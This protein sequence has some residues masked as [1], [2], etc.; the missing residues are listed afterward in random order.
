VIVCFAMLGVLYRVSSGT[1]SKSLA[2]GAL[3][4]T[5]SLLTMHTQVF[6]ITLSLSVDWP[7]IF[8]MLAKLLELL[9]FNLEMLSPECH[10]GHDSLAIRYLPGLFIPLGVVSVMAVMWAGSLVLSQIMSKHV[11]PMKVDPAINAL[12]AVIMAFYVGICKSVFDVFECRENASAPKTM[13]GHDGFLC[14]WDNGPEAQ[15]MLPA[16]AVAILIY[17]IAFGAVYIYIVVIAPSRSRDASFQTRFAFLLQRW[18]PAC[19]LWGVVFIMRNVLCSLVPSITPDALLQL[20]LLLALIFPSFVM[21]VRIWPWREHIANKQ[22]MVL[23]M[24][25]ILTLVAGLALMAPLPDLVREVLNQF[26]FLCYI[27]GVGSVGLILLHLLFLV[28]FAR[29]YLKR[30][31]SISGFA[32]PQDVE[33]SILA[34]VEALPSWYNDHSVG[35]LHCIMSQLCEELPQADARKLRWGLEVLNRYVLECADAEPPAKVSPEDCLSWSSPVCVECP[36]E[37]TAEVDG[38]EHS[39]ASSHDAGGVSV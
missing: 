7:P 39:F 17:I 28:F 31:R 16:A 32:L 24:A 33:H 12:G 30:R 35:D 20:V 19:H 36:D 6:A 11:S 10:F 3:M 38:E 14:L 18:H 25:L 13:R 9:L 15:R 34:V 8:V 26:S 2:R 5:F 23:T 22:D 4:G 1:G 29:K 37:H 21:Q 27:M